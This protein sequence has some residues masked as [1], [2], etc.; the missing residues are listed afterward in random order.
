MPRITRRFIL[1]AI[2]AL[3]VL[4]YLYLPASSSLTPS[5]PRADMH[6]AA[7]AATGGQRPLRLAI[8][9]TD[10]PQPQAND[11]YGGY[12]G[13]FKALLTNACKTLEPPQELEQQFTLSAHDVVNH[14]DS[15]PLLDD[16]DAI[17]ISGSRHNS[18][19]NDPWILKL[20]EFT[21]QALATN[22]IRVVGICFGHQIVSRAVGAKVGRS[23]KGWEVAVTEVDLT[24]KGKQVFGLDK[25]VS[26]QD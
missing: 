23:D 21:Q 5:S 16:I 10:T 22:R 19:D 13:V 26:R 12:G 3:V 9:E 1:P 11:Q 15:Y 14:L 6:S 7:D 18:F 25:M 17:L 4:L 20:V 2:V 8:L 24:D